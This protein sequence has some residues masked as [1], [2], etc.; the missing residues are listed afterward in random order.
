MVT[1]GEAVAVFPIFILLVLHFVDINL[2]EMPES[3]IYHKFLT[4][5]VQSQAV[6]RVFALNQECSVME[7]TVKLCIYVQ[8]DF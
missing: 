1:G 7:F 4:C 3:F 8:K 2:D 6:Q 5:P